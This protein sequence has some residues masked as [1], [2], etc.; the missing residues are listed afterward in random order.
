MQKQ[1][2]SEI[3]K[4]MTTTIKAFA[5]LLVMGWVAAEIPEVRK[6]SNGNHVKIT[7]K[8]CSNVMIIK[9]KCMTCP[10][11]W[12]IKVNPNLLKSKLLGGVCSLNEM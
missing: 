6:Y 5:M 2:I 12:P 10:P 7:L 4:T 11:N 1:D 3:F 9:V 8:V